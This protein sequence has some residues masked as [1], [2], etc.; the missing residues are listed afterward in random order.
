VLLGKETTPQKE[1]HLDTNDEEDN[2]TDNDDGIAIVDVADMTESPRKDLVPIKDG[3]YGDTVLEQTVGVVEDLVVAELPTDS[4]AYLEGCALTW[5]DKNKTRDESFSLSFLDNES[6]CDSGFL[7]LPAGVLPTVGASQKQTATI[8]HNGGQ[9]SLKH[10]YYLV[11]G[12]FLNVSCSDREA[13]YFPPSFPAHSWWLQKVKHQQ[14]F[15]LNARNLVSGLLPALSFVIRDYQPWTKN[16]DSYVYIEEDPALELNLKIPPPTLPG[17][18][19]IPGH[20]FPIVRTKANALFYGRLS[21]LLTLLYSSFLSLVVRESKKK[22]MILCPKPTPTYIL[23]ITQNVTPFGLLYIQGKNAKFGFLDT[24][25]SI[26]KDSII[27][28]C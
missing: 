6:K 19:V 17:M 12:S 28:C 25:F 23:L 26:V 22:G 8:H 27:K 1:M 2:S 7:I 4:L 20:S 24:K 15:C 10:K 9:K 14:H 13:G 18:L 21:I 11:V 5:L 3:S 16:R